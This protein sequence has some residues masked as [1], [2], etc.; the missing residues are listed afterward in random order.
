MV[1][2][3]GLVYPVGGKKV[4]TDNATQRVIDTHNVTVLESEQVEEW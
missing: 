4:C 3:A 1:G 2:G